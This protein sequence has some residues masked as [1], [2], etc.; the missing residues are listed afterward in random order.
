MIDE[1]AEQLINRKLDGELTVDESLELDKLLIRSPQAR[2]LLEEYAAIDEQAAEVLQ[3]VVA[4]PEAR[5]TP[6]NIASWGPA[7]VRLWFSFGLVT[8]VAAA[9][10]LSVLLSLRANLISDGARLQS[11]SAAPL[12][13]RMAVAGPA[14]ATDKMWRIDGPRRET[15]NVEK[16]VIGVWDRHSHSLYL[17]EADSTGSMV[18]PVKANY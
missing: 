6:E 18:E 4:A 7:R 11:P 13:Q 15:L 16:D 12:S 8:A 3:A 2:A 5:V 14:D 9:I 1:R 17:I 10:S